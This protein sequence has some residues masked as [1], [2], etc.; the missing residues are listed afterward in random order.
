MGAENNGVVELLSFWGVIN[1]YLEQNS[2]R[3]GDFQRQ[4]GIPNKGTIQQKVWRLI[5]R[6]DVPY[7]L[8]GFMVEG[9]TPRIIIL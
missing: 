5:E 9:Q 8:E 7:S 2:I 1:H 4:L 3:R 6:L